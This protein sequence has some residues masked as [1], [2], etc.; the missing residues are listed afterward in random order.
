VHGRFE[1]QAQATP[2]RV[3]VQFAGATLTYGQLN[4]R[5]NQLA[6]HLRSLD[7]AP[8]DLV[9]VYIE[10]SLEMVV[11]VLAVL[12]TGAA[13]V[14]L[15]PAF[16]DDRLAFMVA[17]SETRV[18]LT[19]AFNLQAGAPQWPGVT[20]VV[21]D[22]E[23]PLFDAFA[24]HD[25][26]V[27]A[28]ARDL[29]YVIYT[30]GSTGK[31]KGVELEHR[32]VV[33]FLES[34]QATLDFSPDDIL[35]SVTTL[36][37]DIAVLELFVPLITGAQVVVASRETVVDAPRLRA[38]LLATGATV[39]QATPTTWRMLIEDGW[40]G[41]PTLTVVCGGEAMSRGLADA[42]LARCATL[43]NAYG[44]T[45]TTVWSSMHRVVE[46]SGSVP[47]GSAIANTRL[48]VLDARGELLPAGVPGE[49]FIGGDGL[50]RGYLRRE[51]L[52]NER[53]V[54]DPFSDA[55]GARMY[56]TGDLVRRRS[57]GALEYLGRLDTQVK[58]R[59]Y[60]IELGEIESVLA[61]HASVR[62][63]VV[64][65]REF[66]PGDVRLVAYVIADD[67]VEP[68]TLRAH[69]Q[70][71]LPS[72][73]VPVAF[74]EVDAFPLTPNKK[75]D[76][77]ALP[78]PGSISVASVGAKPSE[79]PLPGL[80][81]QLAA[82]WRDVLGVAQVGRHDNFFELGGHSLLAV[83]VF[84]QLQNITGCA[85]PLTS[86][87]RA[88]TIAGIVELVRN[89]GWHPRF[90]SLVEVK[91]EGVGQ[92]FFHVAPFLITA[93]SFSHLARAL[94][95]DHPLYGFQPQG[96]EDEQDIHSTVHEMAA[97]YI[98]EMKQVQ[99]NGPYAIGGHCAGSWVAFEMAQQLQANGD[100]VNALVLVD[101]EPPNFVAP[102]IGHVRY[103]ARRLAYY[104]RAGRLR[105]ALRWKFGLAWQRLLV[106]RVGSPGQRRAATVREAHA[107][108]H[109]QYRSDVVEGDALF[110]RSLESA[111][112]SDKD[113]HL[114]WKELIT[115]ELT[116][117]VVPGSH[118]ALVEEG[119]SRDVAEAIRSVLAGR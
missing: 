57:D 64:A 47:I 18:V 66:A 95:D 81:S 41:D 32:S 31:P 106:R 51:E 67:P 105:D 14:P 50:A 93:L 102:K 49:L 59:G 78:L 26:A 75:I 63:A 42:L 88:P 34:M 39:M 108:A 29:A 86:L 3:A 25:V 109:A 80:E 90:T 23:R 61:R 92:P 9:G 65:A 46:G 115:G 68:A 94:G 117:V 60:R 11:S 19:D 71:E 6:A 84:A 110:V 56:R 15:D 77:N 103:V 2:E 96:L 107:S 118:A 24:D 82:I 70:A 12:K 97:H 27:H 101:A 37:F 119:P 100:E 17:D 4:A 45:E 76:R 113:W 48:Y 116:T 73:M 112:L 5:A 20:F 30:S 28:G 98:D 99:P 54:P 91:P 22:R 13:Y 21:V 83:R 72:Y 44:P 8:G 40:S 16:P 89:D 52:T 53:F 58:V 69:A 55:P 10:R 43:W 87:F 35:L 104:S 85:L 114:M 36:S 62:E 7:V 33:N 111:T 74:V 79:P 38:E 1:R